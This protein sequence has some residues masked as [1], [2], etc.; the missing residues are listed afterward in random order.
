MSKPRDAE[1]VAHVYYPNGDVKE[2]MVTA[3]TGRKFAALEKVY[4]AVGVKGPND[5]KILG[6]KISESGKKKV[7]KAGRQLKDTDEAE[8]ADL[9]SW[10]RYRV[11]LYA[12]PHAAHPRVQTLR[13][14]NPFEALTSVLA[15]VSQPDVEKSGPYIVEVADGINGWRMKM[16]KKPDAFG[17]DYIPPMPTPPRDPAAQQKQPLKLNKEALVSSVADLFRMEKKV[18]PK[19]YHVRQD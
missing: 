19:Q 9:E 11:S 15:L 6:V 1:W 3:Q 7:Y 17:R 16:A 13:A 5:P 12:T 4:T 14:K 10:K 8:N 18:T 2:V